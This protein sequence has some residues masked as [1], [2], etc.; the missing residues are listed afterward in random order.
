M[1]KT[2]VEEIFQVKTLAIDL[3]GVLVSRGMDKSAI[4][5]RVVFA[6]GNIWGFRD[7]SGG[8]VFLRGKLSALCETV[9]LF[10]DTRVHN[11]RFKKAISPK[12]LA[13]LVFKSGSN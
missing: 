6:D 12:D 3:L 7:E 11:R 2:V 9:A 5:G 1:E 8:R 10:Y 4:E 13:L